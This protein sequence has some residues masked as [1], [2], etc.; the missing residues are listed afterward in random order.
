PKGIS[1]AKGRSICPACGHALGA[2]DLVPVASYLL[3]GG[4]CRYCKAP[5]SSR[6][7]VV[8]LLTALL[9]GLV[10]LVLGGGVHAVLVCL[11]VCVLEVVSFIDWDT[12]EIPDLMHLIILA[13]ALINMGFVYISGETFLGFEHPIY[14]CLLGTA[15]VSLPMLLIACLTDGFGGGDIK[16]MAAAGL[17]LG[18]WGILLAFFMGA[19]LGAVYGICLMAG[20]KATGKSAFAFG[21][22]LCTG[23]FLSCL[24]HKEIIEFSYSLD[25]G[26]VKALK[27]KIIEIRYQK[28]YI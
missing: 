25:E 27:S 1:V 14:S 4:K 15:V 23:I 11:L 20:K 5:I 9:F 6:Y 7:A 2:A 8:E 24:F 21:P 3:L 16:L 22:Y 26:S 17:F 28:N 18:I 19:L 13:L 10:Y 12:G